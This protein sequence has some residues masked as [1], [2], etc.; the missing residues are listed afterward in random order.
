MEMPGPMLALRTVLFPMAVAWAAAV[1]A[2]EMRR[3]ET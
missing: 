1:V 2:G 3:R